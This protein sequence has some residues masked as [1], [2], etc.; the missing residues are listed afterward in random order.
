MFKVWDSVLYKR[1]TTGAR[2]IYPWN[3]YYI[4]A[5]DND[6]WLALWKNMNSDRDWSWV[7]KWDIELI[8]RGKKIK[9][10]YNI[11]IKI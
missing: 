5:I 2:E 11:I 8:E 10:K 7:K 1:N 9:N 4:T 6:K 3:E